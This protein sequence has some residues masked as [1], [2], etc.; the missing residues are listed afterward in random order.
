MDVYAIDLG[1]LFWVNLMHVFSF[2]VLSDGSA[3]KIFAWLMLEKI[4]VIIE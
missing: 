1:V 4:S 2:M 3:L